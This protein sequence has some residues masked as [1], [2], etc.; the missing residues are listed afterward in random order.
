MNMKELLGIANRHA[1]GM[2][3]VRTIFIQGDGRSAPSGSRGAPHK[4]AG[5]GP[6]RST[7]GNKRGP[8]R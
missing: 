1:S 5:K 4:V 2:E 7:K 8:K 3:V 6:K